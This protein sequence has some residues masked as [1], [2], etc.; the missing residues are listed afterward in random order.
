MSLLFSNRLN[1]CRKN[2]SASAAF[3]AKR[4]K[5][6]TFFPSTQC[7]GTQVCQ[8]RNAKQP[9]SFNLKVRGKGSLLIVNSKGIFYLLC[10]HK[11][12]TPIVNPSFPI[13]T[14]NSPYLLA[15]DS[16]RHDTFIEIES[17]LFDTSSITDG[18]KPIDTKSRTT[19]IGE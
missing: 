18:V 15:I 5:P 2:R 12:D 13:E 4:Y 9:F 14:T 16:H 17:K 6:I 3:H 1:L 8:N 7:K 19:Q 10:W 11:Q